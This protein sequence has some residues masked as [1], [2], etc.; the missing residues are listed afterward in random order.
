MIFLQLSSRLVPG[1]GE[2][3]ARSEQQCYW[4]EIENMVAANVGQQECTGGRETLNKPLVLYF[5]K[6]KIAI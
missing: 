5:F 6:K 3:A 4:G 1:V 2:L